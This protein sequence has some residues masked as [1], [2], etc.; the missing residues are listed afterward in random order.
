[1]NISLPPWGRI[2]T[3]AR[4]VAGFKAVWLSTVLGAAAGKVWLGPLA[5]LAFRRN[6]AVVFKEPQDGTVGAGNRPRPGPG[7]GD[8]RGV[9]GMGELRARLA[10]SGAC[11]CL[12]SCPVG[13]VFADEHR[14]TGLASRQ[15][16]CWPPFWAPPGRRLRTF[17][18]IALGAGSEAELAFYVAVG[19]FYAAATPLLVELAG[20]LESGGA[21]P[22]T[23]TEPGAT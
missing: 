20:A 8:R 5:L 6:A 13:R 15:T 4:G 7:H 3:L 9:G 2:A 17:T 11:P 22:G 10:P 18:G 19:L 1:M 12:D 23:R 14:R 21:A 16:A